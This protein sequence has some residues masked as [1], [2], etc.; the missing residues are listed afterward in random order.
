[1]IIFVFIL[2]FAALFASYRLFVGPTIQDRL[3]SLNSVTIIFI[4]ILVSLSI[5]ENNGFYLDIALAFI[6]FDFVGMVAFTKH[7]N[8]GKKK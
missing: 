4:I 2:F 5:Q 7:L 3:V 6:F 1:M 8:E